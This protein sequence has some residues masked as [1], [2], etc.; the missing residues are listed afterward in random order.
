M[1]PCTVLAEK[2]SPRTG[3]RLMLPSLE[4]LSSGG[5]LLALLRAP[6]TASDTD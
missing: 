3:E 5:S 4:G 1:F 2:S 6:E